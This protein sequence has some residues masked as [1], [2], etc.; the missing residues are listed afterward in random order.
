MN[1]RPAAQGKALA[2]LSVGAILFFGWETV[3]AACVALPEEML[4]AYADVVV[5]GVA[6]CHLE[7]G[8]C[9]LRAHRIVKDEFRRSG[10]LGVYQLRFD[11]DADDRLRQHFEETGELLMCLNPWEP[12]TRRVEG[13]FY[14]DRLENG[15]FVRQ[16]SAR[17]D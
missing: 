5:D 1:W 10:R 4:I 7:A 12:R 9:R 13:R 14:L 3:G 17:G 11:P 8:T 15:Y 2:H 16:D 6:T